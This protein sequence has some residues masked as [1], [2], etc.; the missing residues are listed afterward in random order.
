MRF[1]G[2]SCSDGKTLAYSGMDVHQWDMVT[3]REAGTLPGHHWSFTFSPDG[4]T[5]AWG[6]GSKMRE[7]NG[8]QAQAVFDALELALVVD[9][10]RGKEIIVWRPF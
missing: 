2:G 1:V 9:G 7:R 10:L 5:L 3:G 8:D 4:K 6:S